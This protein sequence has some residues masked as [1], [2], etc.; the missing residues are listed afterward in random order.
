MSYDRN[1]VIKIALEEVGYREKAS[2]ADLDSK[3]GNAGSANYTKYAR[4]LDRLGNF[5]NGPK[6]GYAYCDVF[7]DWCFVQAY[8]VAAAK[9][10]LCQPDYS[11]GAGCLYS[12]QYFKARGQFHTS[13]PQAGDQ[14]FF[15]Y[16]SG[17]VSHT[18]IVVAV[19]SGL[20]HTVEGNTSDGVYRRTYSL[21][22]SS[23]YG[24]G[25]PAY[26]AAGASTGASTAEPA[27]TVPAAPAAPAEK[28]HAYTYQVTVNLLK[29][30]DYGPQVKN[31]QI[32]LIAK[33]YS[34]GGKVVNGVEQPDG[35]FGEK[36]FEAAFAFQKA[37][38]LDADGDVGG[39]TWTALLRG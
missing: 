15:S 20:V 27:Q 10:L 1:A 2:N 31:L 22:D 29:K 16:R 18:G 39:K 28:V 5:Y 21:S 8:G 36:T 12:A 14:I 30:G 33:G 7:V 17:E 11:A 24:Y 38:G 9:A 23:I 35:E 25:R 3:T 13:N 37:A 19:E 4:D 26:G 32:L 34:C 6:Q